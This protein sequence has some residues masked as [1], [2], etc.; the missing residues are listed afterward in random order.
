[1]TAML[2][3]QGKRIRKGRQGPSTPDKRRQK[4]ERRTNRLLVQFIVSAVLF[5]VVFV[6][7]GLIP[8][9][10]C[11][12]FGEVQQAITSESGL[13]ESVQ[14]LGSAVSE[15]EGVSHALKQWCV[16]TFLPARLTGPIQPLSERL[17][18]SAQYVRHLM[19]ALSLPERPPLA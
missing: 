3:Q 12:V 6:G 19:P 10:V 18:I 13:L 7:G 5:L 8:D 14:T 17:E 16:D 9:R 2:V 4:G 11:D 15:G 1:M